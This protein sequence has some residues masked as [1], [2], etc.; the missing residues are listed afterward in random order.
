MIVKVA[1]PK[2][3]QNVYSNEYISWDPKAFPGAKPVYEA[4]M[5]K[6]K[7]W[8]TLFPM[9]YWYTQCFKAAVESSDST[10]GKKMAEA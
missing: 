1:G 9:G 10:D 4:Y 6:V 7:E 8:S 5:K 3:G 2:F